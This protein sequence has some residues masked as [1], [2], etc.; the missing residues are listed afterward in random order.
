M[1]LMTSTLEF[2]GRILRIE[3]DGFALVKFDRPIG[4]GAKTYGIISNSTNTA[5]VSFS[6]LRPG[7][8]V[9]GTAESDDRDLAAIKTIR[10]TNRSF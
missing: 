7:L 5:S 1:L 8:Y 10:V 3:P 4:P 2:S 9:V 6:G